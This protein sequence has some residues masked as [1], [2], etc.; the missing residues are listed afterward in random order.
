MG[1]LGD[2]N[3]PEEDSFWYDHLEKLRPNNA[4][5]W[6]QPSGLS[7][8]AENIRNLPRGYYV[9]LAEGKTENF[10]N[11]YVHG[12][13][14]YRVEGKLIYQ[15]YNDNLHTAGNVLYPMRGRPLLLG[16]DF[17]LNPTCVI[18][19][20]TPRG[21]L[22]I[23][24][25]IMGDGMGLEQF[26]ANILNP[27]MQTKYLGFQLV[28]QGDPSGNVR[29]QT[30]EK[31]CY[32]VLRKEGYKNVIPAQ[33]NGLLSRHMAVESYLGKLID[34]QPG[35]ILSPN[36][37]MLRKGFNGGYRRKKIPG[38]EEYYDIPD[39][40]MYSHYHDALQY[41]CMGIGDMEKKLESE[42][43]VKRSMH[44]LNVT[45]QNQYHVG[46]N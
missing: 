39:K 31:T 11:V 36:C 1:I 43:R 33:S 45:K 13:Y 4:K 5:L 21:Q 28:G 26:L 41:L 10:K 7:P 40:N 16:F 22:I 6:K 3:P 38:L 9:N 32:Q 27:V 18:G 2:T 20:T 24:D 14:G 23:L 25:E 35:F 12:K 29:G 8:N 44:R 17:A 15:G 34:G 19:Q 46:Y 30:D 42:M 37:A